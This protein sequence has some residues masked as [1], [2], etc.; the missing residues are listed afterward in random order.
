MPNEKRSQALYEAV[1]RTLAD[2][3]MMGLLA[4]VGD[5]K[6]KLPWMDTSLKTRDLFSRLE[7]NLTD[8]E[9]RL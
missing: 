2:T 7:S 1:L 6:A 5:A 8:A 9:S 4:A 3:G